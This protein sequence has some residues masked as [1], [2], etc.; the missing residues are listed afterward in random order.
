MNEWIKLNELKEA[1]KNC[2]PSADWISE[3]SNIKVDNSKDLDVIM[4]I[5]NLLEYG[6]NY[7]IIQS[8]RKLMSI[9]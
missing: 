5:F 2:A 6:N 1:F 8:I 3:I 4:P 7:S 9:L